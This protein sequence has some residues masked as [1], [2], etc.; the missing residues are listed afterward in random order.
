MKPREKYLLNVVPIL[1]PRRFIKPGR[2]IEWS[3]SLRVRMKFRELLHELVDLEQEVESPG[4]K[5]RMLSL[6][7]DIRALPGFPKRYDPDRDLIVPVTTSE[8]R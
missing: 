1:D 6:R 7:E 4:V 8:Q 5:Q 2:R 3:V